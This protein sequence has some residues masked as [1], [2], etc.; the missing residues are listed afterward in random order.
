MN[1]SIQKS[2]TVPIRTRTTPIKI[3][4][5]AIQSQ[6]HWEARTENLH[7]YSL[8]I[9][10][11]SPDNTDLI[12]LPEMFSTGFTMNAGQC[13]DLPDGETLAWMQSHA[14]KM[15]AGITGS[16]IIRE[17]ER[18][19]NRLYFVWPDGQYK[20]YDKRHTFSY[21]GEDEV[22]TRGHK[23][24]IIDYKGWKI[25][26]LICYDLR[27]PV[28]S[29]NTEGFDL[30]LYVANWPASRIHA[31]DT[32]LPA[33]AAENLCYTVGVNRIGQDGN[34]VSYNG[35]SVICDPLGNRM[36]HLPEND[37]G[38][39]SAVLDKE[40]LDTIRNRYRFLDDRDEFL[41]QDMESPNYPT[42]GDRVPE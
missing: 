32:L 17:K 35:H 9:G 8:L 11:L 42:V 39:L 26:P 4:V 19:Y 27:F 40:E 41:F 30:L 15:D 2:T 38:W 24:L 18:F 1:E 34:G 36:A 28:W 6:I 3:H 12:I 25:C 23:R 33:R 7:N 5:Q 13:S 37:V 21:A 10:N 14:N 22:F 20:T 31:W 29:R 16:V